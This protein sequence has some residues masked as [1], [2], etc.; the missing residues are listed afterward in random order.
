MSLR[1]A[2]SYYQFSREIQFIFSSQK[3]YSPAGQTIENLNLIDY[4][5]VKNLLIIL[6]DFIADPPL[7]GLYTVSLIFEERKSVVSDQISLG[8]GQ[9]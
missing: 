3:L 2:W 8:D 5:K 7:S 9:Q 6:R 1:L 4:P